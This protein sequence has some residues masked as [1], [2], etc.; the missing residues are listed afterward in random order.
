MAAHE[1]I[2]KL[3]AQKV[4]VKVSADHSK[5]AAWATKLMQEYESA[6]RTIDA[7]IN[8]ARRD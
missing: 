2:A 4:D 7:T 8:K 6:C 3:T 1:A 5:D